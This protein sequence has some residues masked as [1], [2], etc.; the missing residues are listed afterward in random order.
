[1][2]HSLH[3]LDDARCEDERTIRGH[4]PLRIA[5]FQ[6][7]KCSLSLKM[8]GS[9]TVHSFT[10]LNEVVDLSGVCQKLPATVN[11][12]FAEASGIFVDLRRI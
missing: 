5:F 2:H 11:E 6:R 3:C 9:R 8:D 1:M 4:N 10:I 12:G 7:K